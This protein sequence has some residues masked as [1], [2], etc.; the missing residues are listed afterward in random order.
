MAETVTP[1]LQLGGGCIMDRGHADALRAAAPT[2]ER[3]AR[4]VWGNTVRIGT[5]TTLAGASPRSTVVRWQILDGPSGTPQSLI[6][7]SA[8]QLAD[9]RYDPSVAT[10]GPAW[11]LFND[12]AGLQYL[13]RIFEGAPPAPRL[14]GGDRAR[15]MIVMEDLGAMDSPI[16]LLWG[17]DV[18]EAEAMLVEVMRVVGRIHARSAGQ[19]HL[20]TQLRAALGPVA[21]YFSPAAEAHFPPEVMGTMVERTAATLQITP[22]P[23]VAADLAAVT[24]HWA[25]SSPCLAYTHGDLGVGHMQYRAGQSKFVDFEFGGLRPALTEGVCARVHFVTGG[26]LQ[27]PEAVV[28]RMEAAYRAELVHGHAEATDDTVFVRGLVEGCAHATLGMV[29]WAL[30]GVLDKD[31]AWGSTTYR[32]LLLRR[33]DVLAQT[34]AEAGYL[35]ALGQTAAMM[36]QRLRRL[37]APE[38]YDLPYYPAFR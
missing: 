33:L 31:E 11:R 22:A 23:R 7:K 12:W 4:Q 17:T 5:G 19:Q 28:Q 9:E 16:P 38:A 14:Y 8:V 13:T 3:I 20:Y 10:G 24:A 21:P 25:T 35:E 2:V 18:V 27:Y 1:S 29:S 15:G 34:T 36:A 6:A 37:W 26:G 30:P 32:P